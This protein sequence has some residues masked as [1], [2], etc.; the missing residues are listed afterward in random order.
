MAT[1]ITYRKPLFHRRCFANLL[2][3][4]IFALVFGLLFLASRAIVT[5][6]P[7]YQE[8]EQVVVQQR[9]DSG[10]FRLESD[11]KTTTDVVSYLSRESNGFSAYVKWKDS[12]EAIDKFIV[13]L[14]NVSGVENRDK[15]Q[16]DYDAYRLQAKYKDIAMFVKDGETIVENPAFVEIADL[17]TRF[18]QAYA[19]YLDSRCQAYLVTEVVSYSEAIHYESTCL[20]WAEIAPS[21]AMGGVLVY[22]V[23]TLFFRRGRMTL[24]KALYRIGL[25]DKRILVPKFSISLARFGIFYVFELLATPFT[26]GIP[27]LVSFSLMAFS[28]KKQGLPDYFLGLNEVDV[29]Q[30]KIYFDKAEIKLSDI[31]GMGQAPKFRSLTGLDEDQ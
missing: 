21:Y 14:G 10:L 31:P 20:Y 22:F 13:Y 27:L 19:P 4:L 30:S 9:L 7:A 24:G 5:S 25:V 16:K 12:K 28:K 11:K 15:V 26:F 6:T 29:S 18:L 17:N 23:P 2:D 8:Q 3:L 1:E